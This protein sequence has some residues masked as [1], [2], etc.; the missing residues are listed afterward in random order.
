MFLQDNN[1]L[2]GKVQANTKNFPIRQKKLPA[3]AV[4]IPRPGN[5]DSPRGQ[6]GFPARAVRIPRPGSSD[7]PRGQLRF[8]ARAISTT[9]AGKFNNPIRGMEIIRSVGRAA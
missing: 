5:S 7:S 6:L 1:R 9:R 4:Q 8:P 3:R 2:L